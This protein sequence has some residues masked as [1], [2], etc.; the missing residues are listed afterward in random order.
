MSTRGSQG[1]V[2]GAVASTPPVVPANAGRLPVWRTV[3]DSYAFVLRRQGALARLALPWLVAALAVGYGGARLGYAQPAW[4]AAS[5]IHFLGSAALTVA[6]LRGAVEGRPA[7]W[8]AP[9]DAGV[10]ALLL[11]SVLVGVL[12]LLPGAGVA[13]LGGR[14]VAGVLPGNAGQV[15]GV[16]VLAGATLAILYA[17]MRL[18]LYV[19]AGALRVASLGLADAWR[20]M[21]GHTARLIAVYLSV[22]LLGIV[23]GVVGIALGA[24]LLVGLLGPEATPGLVLPSEGGRLSG[25]SLLIEALVRTVGYGL[26]ALNATVLAILARHV[27]PTAIASPP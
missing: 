8:G 5:L 13:L 15:L 26:A 24:G 23:V 16:V 2:A 7:G 19:V 4:A 27:L 20:V 12:C 9:L 3:H 18:Q 1:S 25:A 11:R 14:L 17:L 10:A 6:W 21:G 22:S